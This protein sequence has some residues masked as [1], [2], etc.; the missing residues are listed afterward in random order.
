MEQT[1]MKTS[2][3]LAAWRVIW[4]VL[5]FLLLLLLFFIIGLVIGYAVI[6]KGNFWEVLN[7]DT[8]KHI[9]DLILT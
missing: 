4:R 5:L 8:W 1:W 3:W 9:L 2:T 6:G 7:Q